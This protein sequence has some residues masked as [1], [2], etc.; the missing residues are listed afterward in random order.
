MTT[1][2]GSSS[3]QEFVERRRSPR[4]EVREGELVLVTF[5]GKA[6]VEAGSVALNF[7][8]GGFLVAGQFPGTS[9]LGSIL[10]LEIRRGTTSLF[11][12]FRLIRI[13]EG[14]E[15]T[16]SSW[17]VQ[18]V[19]PMIC[20]CGTCMCWFTSGDSLEKNIPDCPNCNT[21]QHA[22]D[23]PVWAFPPNI[24]D[25]QTDNPELT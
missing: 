12:Y 24:E 9:P 22:Q 8:K 11:G 19:S 13:T 25:C 3:E 17:C 23:T 5:Y 7:S 20:R 18:S 2:N 6:P 4:M 14:A 16:S 21:N 15:P 1:P 10:D